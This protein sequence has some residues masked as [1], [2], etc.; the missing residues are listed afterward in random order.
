MHRAF[1]PAVP[2]AGRLLPTAQSP[3]EA[4]PDHQPLASCPPLAM[5]PSYSL[6]SL[7]HPSVFLRAGTWPGPLGP[8]HVAS[9]SREPRALLALGG[10]GASSGA[11]LLSGL[12]VSALGRQ[13]KQQPDLEWP[14]GP[15]QLCSATHAMNPG[16]ARTTASV[17]VSPYTCQ[18]QGCPRGLDWPLSV[19]PGTSAAPVTLPPQA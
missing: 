1:A 12:G 8:Q 11:L 18:P 3:P 16:E 10:K 4:F 15:A 5:L 14:L 13:R 17:Q 19:P 7:C 9:T 6:K 2:A